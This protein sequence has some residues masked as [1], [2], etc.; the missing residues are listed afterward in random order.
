MWELMANPTVLDLDQLRK[1]IPY[2]SVNLAD[3]IHEA[4]VMCFHHGQHRSGVA[5]QIRDFE[6]ILAAATIVW[7]KSFSD[8]IQ[9]TFGETGY[10][11]EFAA[12]GIA[13]LTIT[14]F[15]EYTVIE[16]SIRHDGVDFWLA[17]KD[18]TGRHTFQRAAR[19]ESKGITEARYPSDIK[20]QLDR[21]IKQTKQ[22]DHTDLPVYIIATEFSQPVIYMV[23][24]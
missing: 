19:M 1:A 22:S 18:E 5:C 6:N 4:V 16:R 14:E 17:S 2:M 13:C 24:R 8:I 7:T 9:R 12:E 21:G 11:V 3:L 23:Q 20:N 10:A 15:T